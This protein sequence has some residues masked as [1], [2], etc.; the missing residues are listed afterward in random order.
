MAITLA[1]LNRIAKQRMLDEMTPA[2][3]LKGVPTEE[4]LK[5]VPTRELAK[6]MLRNELQREPTR[7]EVNE[8]L[9]SLKKKPAR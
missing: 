5:G 6:E 4:R 2:E 8:L 9:R 3:R 7:S 1:D